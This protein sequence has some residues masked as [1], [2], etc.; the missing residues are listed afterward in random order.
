M[1]ETNRIGAEEFMLIGWVTS[2]FLIRFS[3]TS[4]VLAF[5]SL[6]VDPASGRFSD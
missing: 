3:F 1:A 2:S 5:R 4:V 6:F